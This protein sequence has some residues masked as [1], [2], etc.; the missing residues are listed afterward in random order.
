MSFEIDRISYLPERAIESIL[1][2]L[3]MTDVVRTSALSRQWRYRWNSLSELRFEVKNR[4]YVQKREVLNVVDHVL[5]LHY[6]PLNTFVLSLPCIK[7]FPEI[8]R[9]I[10]FVTSKKVRSITIEIY[11]G[12]PFKL[13]SQLCSPTL[14]HLN[15]YKCKFPPSH[16][17][18]SFTNLRSLYLKSIPFNGN[19]LENLISNCP[20]LNDLRLVNVK[21]CHSLK[22]NA[23]N[24]QH[25]EILGHL[26]D[27]VFED[28]KRLR[29]VLLNVKMDTEPSGHKRLPEFLSAL[30]VVEKLETTGFLEHFVVKN[31]PDIPPLICA[32][33]KWLSIQVKF[34]NPEAV[35]ATLLMFKCLPN[36]EQLRIES[37]DTLYEDESNENLLAAYYFMDLPFNELKYVTITKFCAWK[38]EVDLIRLLLINSPLLEKLKIQYVLY[39]EGTEV[40]KELMQFKRVSGQTQILFENKEYQRMAK[41][42]RENNYV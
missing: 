9:W 7:S 6:G 10:I 3:S 24:L 41:K 29:V 32:H 39:N 8:N 16:T 21:Y 35:L 11:E 14:Y 4:W 36:L 28:T 38:V 2:C 22:I 13:P 33:L 5:L 15:L 17:F 20:L 1:L 27:L 34:H 37:L 12:K 19:E 26:K 31:V 25:I 18:K 40:L 30:P 42:C 23:P